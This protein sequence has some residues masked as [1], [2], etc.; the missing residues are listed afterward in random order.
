MTRLIK[1]GSVFALCAVAGIATAS[2]QDAWFFM[3]GNGAQ[4]QELTNIVSH[5]RNGNGLVFTQKKGTTNWVHV[6]VPSFAADIGKVSKLKICYT[7]GG[8]SAAITKIELWDGYYL[9]K[10]IT[11]NWHGF[12]KILTLDLG[13]GVT[14]SQGL[15]VSIQ[16]RVKGGKDMSFNIYSVSAG[17]DVD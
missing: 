10:T 5:S 8:P 14:V 17:M 4:L 3:H 2:A 12:A 1:R 9:R 15:G 7:T 16:T 6:A 13:P 11:G